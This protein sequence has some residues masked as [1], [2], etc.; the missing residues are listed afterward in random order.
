MAASRPILILVALLGVATGGCVQDDGKRFNPI[1]DITSVSDD[2]ERELGLQF[3][4]QLHQ[5]VR[6][7]EDPVVAGFINDLGQAIVATIEPQPFIYRFRVIDADSLNAFAVPGGYI[8]FHSET[9]LAAGSLDELAGVMGHEI[10]H[11]NGHHYARMR[12]K[13]QIPDILAGLAGMAAA[14]ASG[15]PEPMMAAQA[16]NVAVQL[17]FSREFENEA[18]RYGSVF[19]ARAGWDPGAITRFF[20]RIL[21]IQKRRPHNI[22]PYLFSHPDVE[23][24]IASVQQQAEDLR[25]LRDPDPRLEEEFREAQARLGWLIDHRRESLPPAPPADDPDRLDA[26]L[27]R[28]DDLTEERRLDEA[29]LLLAQ[30]ESR[31]P[32]DPRAPF[33]IA[34]L[35]TAQERYDEA[36]EAYRRTVRLD[37]RRALVFYQMGL[38]HKAAGSRHSAVYA[39]EQASRR[40][41]ATSSLRERAEWQIEVLVFPPLL[42]GGFVDADRPP[43]E[44]REQFPASLRRV[45]WRARLHSRYGVYR[46]ELTLHWTDPRGRLVRATP[47]KPDGGPWLRSTLELPADSAPGEW[48]VEVRYQRDPVARYTFRVGES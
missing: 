3:D 40:A 47:V 36:I 22:P 11:V 43:S 6:V 32:N 48:A 26:A 25:P 10:A 17:K 23:D 24:R 16:A 9:V 2:E 34:E 31:E 27:A 29:L 1:E 28:A 39:F 21:Q 18:D 35:L 33:R 37:P 41:G 8:Y 13:T 7:I 5:K 45:A 19:M 20:E 30:I 44:P 12:K 42:D 4:R 15:R 38:A 46:D 14:V